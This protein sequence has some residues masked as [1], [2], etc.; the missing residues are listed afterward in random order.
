[1]TYG[2][3]SLSRKTTYQGRL[4]CVVGYLAIAAF[5]EGLMHLCWVSLVSGSGD[6]LCARVYGVLDCSARTQSIPI[7]ACPS[8]RML[9][10][11][12]GCHLVLEL[13]NLHF[14][15]GG[16]VSHVV[17]RMAHHN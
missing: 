7:L 4:V 17:F 10:G 13:I 1:M 16:R 3:V 14:I 12:S 5:A 11:T 6:H 8:E 15:S 9:S 2:S